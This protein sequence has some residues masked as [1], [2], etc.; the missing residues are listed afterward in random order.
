MYV[1]YHI[2]YYV[3][4]RITLELNCLK[5]KNNVDRKVNTKFVALVI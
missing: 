2:Y 5:D 3:N 4:N 1:E